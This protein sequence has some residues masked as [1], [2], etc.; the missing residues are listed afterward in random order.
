M[1]K[2]AII[3]GSTTG[4]TSEI[5][6]KIAKKLNVPDSDIFDV[7]N[8]KENCTKPY[9]L[10]ILGSSTW[11]C[12]EVQDDWYDGVDILSKEDLSGKQVALFGCGDSSSYSDTFCDAMGVI[13]KSLEST[14]CEFTGQIPVDGYTFDSSVAV[15]DGSFIGLALDEENESD[16]TDSR[17]DNWVKLIS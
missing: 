2:I 15:I 12:G 16:M 1:K 3:Y 4:T 14:G 10:L 11:G 8:I 5:A 7:A 17:I 6:K 13:A 9:D